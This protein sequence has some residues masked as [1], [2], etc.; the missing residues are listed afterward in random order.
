[1]SEQSEAAAQTLGSRVRIPLETWT[2]VRVFLRCDVLCVVR[3][4]VS[5]RSPVQGG[6]PTFKWIHKF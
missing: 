4:L 3:G 1:M 2:C 5:G 6:L